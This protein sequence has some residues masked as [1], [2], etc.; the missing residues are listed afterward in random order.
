PPS[1]GGGGGPRGGGGETPPADADVQITDLLEQAE[2]KF[3]AAD[4]AQ[5]RG[6]TVL[7]ARLMEQAR[8]L[9]A[10]AVDLAESR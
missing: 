8:D 9:V 3:A 1:T 5:A 2:A 6:D 7:W 4:Q 10:Q